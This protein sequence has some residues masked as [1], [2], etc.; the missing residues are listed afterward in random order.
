MLSFSE[1]AV[2]KSKFANFQSQKPYLVVHTGVCRCGSFRILGIRGLD[3]LL[4]DEPRFRSGIFPGSWL[5]TVSDV[6]VVDTFG[7]LVVTVKRPT[8][9]VRFVSSV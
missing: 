3:S 5:L 8:V 4:I 9:V 6:S 7:T 2:S 1:I